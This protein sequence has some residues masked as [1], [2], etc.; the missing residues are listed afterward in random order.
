MT[1]VIV[2]SANFVREIGKS[3][4]LSAIWVAALGPYRR[5]FPNYSSTLVVR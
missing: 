3:V 1:E 5:S 2:T 4:N